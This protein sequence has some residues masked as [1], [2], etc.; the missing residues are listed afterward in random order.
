[1]LL[2]PTAYFYDAQSLNY[3]FQNTM[4]ANKLYILNTNNLATFYLEV[5]QNST[6]Y[7][8]QINL[9]PL[10]K[11]LSTG[12]TISSGATWTLLNDNDIT[13]NPQIILP[14]GLQ[15][16][17]GFSPNSVNKY[18]FSIDSQTNNLYIPSSLTAL[19]SVSQSFFINAVQKTYLSHVIH[20]L[21]M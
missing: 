3:F 14:T 6:Y 21:A 8:L 11:Q 20:L 7:G 12:Q 15:T 9:Y 2:S 13:Y 16:W 5:V 18:P 17:F 19:Q 1:M 10:P 4:L